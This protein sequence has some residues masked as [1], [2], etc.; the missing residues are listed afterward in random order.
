MRRVRCQHRQKWNHRSSTD[1][2]L[3]TAWETID[4]PSGLGGVGE[5]RK[6]LRGFLKGVL[7][8]KQATEWLSWIRNLEAESGSSWCLFLSPRHA[9][10]L[11]CFSPFADVS[12]RVPLLSVSWTQQLLD[13]VDFFKKHLTFNLFISMEDRPLQKYWCKSALSGT[14]RVPQGFFLY[15]RVLIFWKMSY[16]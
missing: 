13:W 1:R 6:R 16:K 15:L 12:P 11:T 3:L 7:I 9:H 8:K 2:F 10:F 14:N 4:I 5:Q